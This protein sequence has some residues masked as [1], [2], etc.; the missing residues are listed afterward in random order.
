MFMRSKKMSVFMSL[1]VR[2]EGVAAGGAL[3]T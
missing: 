3:L 1:S 2:G